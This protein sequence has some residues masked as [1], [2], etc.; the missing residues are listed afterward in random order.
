MN[1]PEIF[2]LQPVREALSRGL[3]AKCLWLARAPGRETA[4]IE[5]AAEALKL[6][7]K[8]VGKRA[9]SERLGHERHQGLLLELGAALPAPVPLEQLLHQAEEAGEQPLLLMAD[10]V[11]DP[12]N[13]GAMMRSAYALGA[14]GIVLPS[15]RAASVTPAVVRASAGAALSLPTV[16]LKNLKHAL[17][18]LSA[19]GVW[20]AAAVLDGAPAAEA[21]L[22]LPLALI[23]GAEHR[24]V[25]PSLAARC[26]LQLS[27][28]LSRG[29]DSLN[30]SVA[31]GI[32]LY[33]VARQRAAATASVT[34]PT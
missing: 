5:A 17:K 32:L 31:A 14:H 27:I 26:D 20:T 21:R 30:A 24:G 8:R 34:K 1:E 6:P 15:V 16:E 23:V 22:D 2:G 18:S 10:G 13:L 11:Q 29:F 9:L 12:H 3:P 33:E 7:I 4:A 19:H 28:P 25:K